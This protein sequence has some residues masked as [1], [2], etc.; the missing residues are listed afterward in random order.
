MKTEEATA[1]I[2]LAI[3][4][5]GLSYEKAIE[6]CKQEAENKAAPY[7]EAVTRLQSELDRVRHLKPSEGKD[8]NVGD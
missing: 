2:S 8:V 5:K 7:L 4:E 1:I 3:V 6:W